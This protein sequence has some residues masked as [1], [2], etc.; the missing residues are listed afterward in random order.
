MKGMLI[1]SG[2]YLTTGTQDGPQ[3]V[4]ER[5]ISLQSCRGASQ[6]CEG[7]L[8]NSF[9]GMCPLNILGGNAQNIQFHTL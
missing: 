3:L 5:A 6:I 1:L 9:L 4:S 2:N 8:L 7:N